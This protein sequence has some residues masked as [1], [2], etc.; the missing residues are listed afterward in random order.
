MHTYTSSAKM[1]SLCVSFPGAKY[2]FRKA[3]SYSAGLPG[4]I[5]STDNTNAKLLADSSWGSAA[6]P[7]HLEQP[8]IQ[9]QMLA[10]ASRQM[11]E[12]IVLASSPLILKVLATRPHQGDTT[13]TRTDTDPPEL[14]R[15]AVSHCPGRRAVS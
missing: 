13:P 5:V 10:H 6:W 12:C 14:T 7:A 4:E 3:D 8:L 11:V 1:L 2:L 15:W 9:T